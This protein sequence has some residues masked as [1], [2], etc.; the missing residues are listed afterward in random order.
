ML[1]NLCSPKAELWGILDE[2]PGLRNA[3]I[4]RPDNVN[5]ARNAPEYPRRCMPVG[6]WAA[7]QFEVVFGGAIGGLYSLSCVF[8]KNLMGL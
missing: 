4:A 3:R 8:W 6:S 2:T 5:S 1:K 7:Q